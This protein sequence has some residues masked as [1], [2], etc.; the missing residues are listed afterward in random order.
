MGLVAPGARTE[1][2]D[3]AGPGAV[4]AGNVRNVA[5]LSRVYTCNIKRETY[6]TVE[7]CL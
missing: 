7:F 4:G 2:R 1:E 6:I 5:E 3:G